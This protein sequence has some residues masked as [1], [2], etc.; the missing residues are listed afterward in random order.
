VIIENR[1]TS[2]RNEELVYL[3]CEIDFSLGSI[4]ALDKGSL[5][6]RA[7]GQ[8]PIDQKGVSNYLSRSD[9]QGTELF[10]GFELLL[11]QT[12][13]A[14]RKYFCADYPCIGKVR[15]CYFDGNQED[16]YEKAEYGTV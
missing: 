16:Q 5:N 12:S 7:V 15:C 1:L 14:K 8:E 4:P 3:N 2:R 9:L 11:V 13:Q 6:I 10:E